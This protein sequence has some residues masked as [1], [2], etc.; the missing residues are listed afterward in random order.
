MICVI[1]DTTD[2]VKTFTTAAFYGRVDLQDKPVCSPCASDAIRN[3]TSEPD[4]SF[5]RAKMERDQRYRY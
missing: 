4:Y 2:D 3:P 5:E 1:C